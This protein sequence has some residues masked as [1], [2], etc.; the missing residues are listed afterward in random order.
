[1]KCAHFNC[2][3]CSPEYVFRGG[4]I[5][6]A[7]GEKWWSAGLLEKAE[8]EIGELKGRVERQTDWYQQRFNRLRKWVTEEVEPLSKEVAHK[9]FSICAN[10]SPAPHESADWTN[11]MHELKLRLEQAEQRVKTLTAERDHFKVMLRER[12]DSLLEAREAA[13]KQSLEFRAIAKAIDAAREACDR[14]AENH[15]SSRSS[16]PLVRYVAAM[17]R[18]RKWL[19]EETDNAKV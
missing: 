18:L 11:T 12:A 17:D 10:G 2:H 4:Y 19:M 16:A 1:M 9:Y 6:D 13:E 5:E 14:E 8:K 3:A 15:P 7:S